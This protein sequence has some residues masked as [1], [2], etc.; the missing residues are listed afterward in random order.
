TNAIT[1]LVNYMT[2]THLLWIRVENNL[3]GC[4][5]VVSYSMT[6]DL[7]PEPVITTP[8]NSHV[9]CVDADGTLVRDLTLTA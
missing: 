2:Y 8:N 4:A 1:D 9:I 5:R 7:L 3:T 6:V